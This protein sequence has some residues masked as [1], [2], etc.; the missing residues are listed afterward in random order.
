VFTQRPETLRSGDKI[1]VASILQH[2]SVEGIVHDLAERKVDSLSYTSFT[3]LATFFYDRFGVA[4]AD[5]SQLQRLAEAIEIRNISV[6]NRCMISRRFVTRLNRPQGEVGTR[7]RLDVSYLYE[8][9]PLLVDTVKAVD[10]AIARKLKIH[11]V[12][13]KAVGKADI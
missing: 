8:L 3:D 2:D 12:R 5:E 10:R 13:F 9:V 11:G 1:E 6:H 7:Y 4:I